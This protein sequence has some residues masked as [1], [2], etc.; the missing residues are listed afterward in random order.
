[1]ETKEVPTS[2]AEK[3]VRYSAG[4]WLIG[5]AVFL[6]SGYM[7]S[8]VLFSTWV[9]CDI[10]ANG[11]YQL[12]SLVATATGMAMAST[13]LWAVMRKVTGRQRLL[14]PLVLTVIA[15]AALLWPVL[16]VWYVSPGHPESMCQPGGTPVGWPGW[17]PL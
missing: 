1:M 15:T 11:A 12:V 3:A 8:L 5:S 6:G 9:N 4:A 17:L 16:A 7:T 2:P 13:V 14:L 10:G